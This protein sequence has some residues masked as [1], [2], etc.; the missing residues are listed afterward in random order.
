MLP[1]VEKHSSSTPFMLKLL[2][3]V[4][5]HT[6]READPQ[7]QEYPQE[8]P[9]SFYEHM[10]RLALQN[11]DLASLTAVETPPQAHTRMPSYIKYVSMLDF[12][13]T[14]IDLN[15]HEHIEL[16][17]EKIRSQA[18]QIKGQEL[19]AFWIPIIHKLCWEFKQKEINISLSAPHWT[20]IFRSVLHAYQTNFVGPMP[21]NPPARE[22]VLCP[23]ED[24]AQLN[25]YLADP[26][27]TEGRFPLDQARRSH[28]EE[29]LCIAEAEVDIKIER[30][31]IPCT[32]IVTKT[33]KYGPAFEA[34]C[35]RRL[36]A[37]FKFAAFELHMLQG[38]LGVDHYDDLLHMFMLDRP[39]PPP[40][41]PNTPAM[42]F[43]QDP[44]PLGPLAQLDAEIACI[45]DPPST[46]DL[47]PN[48]NAVAG[49]KRKH[50][51]LEDTDLTGDD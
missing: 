43:Q 6:K 39:E 10:A 11:L 28:L 4:Y 9:Q 17:A 5:Q 47:D 46:P 1:I 50:I 41:P 48:P 24:C 23:C 25:E 21:Q 26:N 13:D 19:H 3:I 45:G 42:P 32:L 12:I 7:D 38:V 15:L 49:V 16:L 2:E 40:Q 37:A 29:E 20:E 27:K 33:T 35:V 44:S 31:G 30:I 36:Q 34:W 14:L 8:E 18:E 22:G 51:E